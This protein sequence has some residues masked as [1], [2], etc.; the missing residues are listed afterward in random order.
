MKA[1]V[2]AI[3]VG[4]VKGQPMD[5]VDTVHAVPGFGL[6]GDRYWQAPDVPAAKR[7]PDREITLIESEAI[8]A[9][10]RDEEFRSTWPRAA[11]TW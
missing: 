2:V 6:S 5:A 7:G 9:L 11:A 1:E 4:K 8:E 10:V 3:F